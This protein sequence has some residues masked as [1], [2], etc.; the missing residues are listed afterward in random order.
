L[1]KLTRLANPYPTW[2]NGEGKR[3]KLIKSEIKKGT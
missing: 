1:K 2:Q 3:H